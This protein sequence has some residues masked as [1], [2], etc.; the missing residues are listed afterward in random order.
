MKDWLGGSYIVMKITQN[1]PVVIPLL[2]IGY[3][4]SSSKVL[5]FI[6]TEGGGSNEPSDPYLSCFPDIYS[7]VYVRPRCSS[8][9]PRQ[10][11]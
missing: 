5:G 3:K 7:N 10:V 4:Y 1:V 6:A 8:L 9:L 11:F 2:A